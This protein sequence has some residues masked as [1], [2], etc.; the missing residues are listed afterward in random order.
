MQY[1]ELMKNV[2]KLTIY[3]S[4]SPIK[5]W[6][7]K[8]HNFLFDYGPYSSEGIWSVSVD[9]K[10]YSNH[11]NL[12]SDYEGKKFRRIHCPQFDS[13]TLKECLNKIAP[14]YHLDMFP[15]H[16]Q[17]MKLHNTSVGTWKVKEMPEVNIVGRQNNW[18]LPLGYI[19]GEEKYD[20]DL[21]TGSFKT[22]R[23][24]LHYYS[25]YISQNLLHVFKTT[26]NFDKSWWKP[27]IKDDVE[28]SSLF[29]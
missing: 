20:Q 28:L 23:G 21:S 10:F 9:R 5:Q 3:K 14:Y 22:K 15:T 29:S 4:Q 7:T 17:D 12:N 8:D 16:K 26:T 24:L 19:K 2:D 25:D 18:Y 27:F 6:R 1:K 11:I 13:K